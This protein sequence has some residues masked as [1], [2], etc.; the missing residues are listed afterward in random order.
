M[1]SGT[2]YQLQREVNRQLRLATDIARAQAEISA[3]GKRILSASD[4]PVGAARIADITRTQANQEAWKTNLNSAAA[5]ASNAEG[6]LKTL[7]ATFDRVGELMLSVAN[8]T[9][10]A[11]NRQAVALELES[12]AEEVATLRDTRDSRGEA[13]FP[14]ASSSIRIPVGPDLDI[15]AVGTREAVFDGVAT[16]SGIQSLSAILN[17]AVTAVR[18]NDP[19]AIQAALAA[20]NAATTHVISAHAAQGSRGARIDTLLDR[21]QTN[22]VDLKAERSAIESSDIT[23]L[24]ATI[25]ARQLSLDAAQATFA[26]INKSTLFDLLR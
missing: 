24:V 8:G 14:T 26:R 1:I 17:N 21:I 16:G 6:V 11:E 18:S 10:S 3:G 2:R 4:D 20:T 23:E 7:N 12:I 5:L 22:S 15:A 9:L 13:L 25:Q 19:A